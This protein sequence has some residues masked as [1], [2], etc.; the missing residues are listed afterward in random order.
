MPE[1]KSVMLSIQAQPDTSGIRTA[2]LYGEEHTVIPTVALV[3][4]VLWPANAPSPELALAEEFGRF[5]GGWDGRPVTYD[6][7]KINGEAVAAGSPDVLDDVGL[8]QLFNTRLDGKKLKTEIWI[9]NSRIN[10]LGEDAQEVIRRLREGDE[11]VE[12]STGLFTMSEH[13][14]GTY[15]GQEFSAIWRNI[16]PDHLAILPSGTT[17]ACSVADGCGAP[18]ENSKF[19]PV[20]NAA[21]IA[22][23]AAEGEPPCECPDEKSRF[24]RL[25]DNL[26]NFFRKQE[27]IEADE[28]AEEPLEESNHAVQENSTM[29]KDQLVNGLIDNASTQFTDDDRD[30]LSTLSEAQLARLTPVVNEGA[31]EEQTQ[32]TE[33]IS[34]QESSQ[35]VSTE[36]YIAGAPEEMQA[37]LN[38]GLRMHRSRKDAVVKN[39]M[40]NARNTFSREDLECKGLSE[41][42]S[43]ASLATDISFEGAAPV[44]NSGNAEE[45]DAPPPP[46]QVF[47]LSARA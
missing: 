45:D 42:E 6:H 46:P 19:V 15:E 43:I 25:M 27:A 28:S 41:L 31:S 32:E 24:K 39:I 30:W 18:R 10:S 35:P 33:T 26:E 1:P 20:M 23:S 44:S 29:D 8:G 16:V 14:E 40:E 2:Q 7:P 12:V 38:E 47:D 36:D 13:L 21:R 34:D 11:V 3:E 5:P 9:N 17:G 37:V 4:G 22:I